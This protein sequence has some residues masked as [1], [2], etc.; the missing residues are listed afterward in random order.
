MSHTEIKHVDPLRPASPSAAAV[1]G[2]SIGEY[3]IRR[4]QD[5]GIGHVFGIPGDYIL[6]FYSMLDDSP[7]EIVDH[8]ARGLR[9]LRGRCLCPRP[10]HGGGVRDLLRRRAEPVQLDRRGLCREVAGGGDHRLAGPEGAAQQSAVAPPGARLSHAVR[11]VRKAV[12]RRHRA[13]R[14]AD[15]LSRDRP[16]A[17]RR[18]PLQAAGVH[19]DSARHGGRRARAAAS[20]R[21]HA[22][23]ER[24]RGAGRGGGR[25]RALARTAA[26][27]R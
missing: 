13:E 19:R 6:P 18:G 16:R 10:R 2:L 25:G 11:R 26:S 14:S 1:S 21:A 4:L 22:T 27:S 15:R 12:H 3:L 8:H 23:G 24:S 7:L 20:F 9:R 5:Y 17:A